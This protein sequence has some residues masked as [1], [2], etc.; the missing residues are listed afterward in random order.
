MPGS[1]TD[2]PQ[3][4]MF[5]PAD[6]RLFF[7]PAEQVLRCRTSP[8]V[9]AIEASLG[10]CGRPHGTPLQVRTCLHPLPGPPD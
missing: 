3:P 5:I 10:T 2:I 9:F 1:R 8:A 7:P 6:S 4:S